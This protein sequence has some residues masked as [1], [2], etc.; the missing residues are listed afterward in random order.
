[1]D[2]SRIRFVRPGERDAADILAVYAP[3]VRDTGVTFEY[4]VPSTDDF[5]RRID[6]IASVYPYLVFE[7]G[8]HV[9]AYAYPSKYME[10]AAYA[11]GVQVS[12]YA[13]PEERGSGAARALYNCLFAMLA[14]LGYCTAYALIT[15][16]NE[17][18][19]RFHSSFG[20]VPAGV[21]HKA[22]YKLGTWLDVAWMEKCFGRYDSE[23]AAPRPV[24]DLAP[25]FSAGIFSRYAL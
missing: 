24:A 18:S 2:D 25:E 16:P 5:V 6:G 10:R 14:E 8:G 22:G 9:T 17:R 23:P 7:R 1:M 21:H 3:F 13:A 19:V 20:F 11:W 4:D 12:V 15:L